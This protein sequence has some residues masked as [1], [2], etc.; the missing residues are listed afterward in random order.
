MAIYAVKKIDST[1]GIVKIRFFV[2]RKLRLN[3]SEVLY[4]STF[5]GKTFSVSEK[6][7]QYYVLAPSSL[8][9]FAEWV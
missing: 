2:I 9:K 1:P 7:K 5:K 4:M 6:M 3:K 8:F